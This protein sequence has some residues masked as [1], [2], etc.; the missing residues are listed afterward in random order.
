MPDY[1]P[2]AIA[3]AFVNYAGHP[4]P[5]MKLQKLTYIADGWNLAI[6]GVPLVNTQPEAWDNG[7]VFRSIWNRVRDLG[8]T[9]AG[10]VRDYDGSVPEV[11]L[12][13]DEAAVVRHVWNKYGSKSAYELSAM[14]HQ[15]NT[16][17]TRAYYGGGRNSRI[18]NEDVRSHYLAL[19][20][21]GRAAAAG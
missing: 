1:S 2:A 4:L 8:V 21:A 16:P 6:A 14:T 11:V 5:Q 9:A 19:A 13:A 10:K 15:P 12:T 3:N 18:T 20:Q 7:P 17:W